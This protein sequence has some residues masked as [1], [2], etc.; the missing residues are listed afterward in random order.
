MR[1]S[2]YRLPVGPQPALMAAL[3]LM[4]LIIGRGFAQTASSGSNQ[5]TGATTAPTAGS[6]TTAATANTAPS[7]NSNLPALTTSTT[8]SDSLPS[9]TTSS[10]SLPSLPAPSDAADAATTYSIPVATVPPTANAPYMQ[11]SNLPEG[12][13]FIAVGGGL[14]LIGLSVLAWRALVAWSI[15]RS[16]R[17][18]ALRH[19]QLETKAVPHSKKKQRRSSHHHH[20]SAMSMEK[21]STNHRHSNISSKIPSSQSGLFFSPTAGAGMHTQANRGSSYLP[22]GY[23][24]AGSA[25]PGG[26]H[27]RT[28]TSSPPSSP[29]L[30]PSRGQEVSYQRM[31]NWGDSNSSLNLN[32]PPQGRAPSAYLEDLFES[33]APASRGEHTSQ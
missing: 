11:Q 2:R 20:G 33:H 6:G 28:H 5:S 12:T 31:S 25:A 15:N 18:A 32:H 19:A 26:T 24:A 23:Y 8:S 21:L 30:P 9:L 4:S 29:T 7:S 13:V 16:V 1:L 22:A 14:G 3:F 27:S 10:A 17:R